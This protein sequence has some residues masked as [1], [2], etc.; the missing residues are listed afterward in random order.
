MCLLFARGSAPLTSGAASIF[1][2]GAA[3]RVL[4]RAPVVV[5]VLREDPSHSPRE[6]APPH[7]R[8]WEHL[9]ARETKQHSRKHSRILNEGETV[10]GLKE[11]AGAGARTS[12]RKGVAGKRAP[13]EAECVEECLRRQRDAEK[14]RRPPPNRLGKDRVERRRYQD[15]LVGATVTQRERLIFTSRA[16]RC[17]QQPAQ[18]VGV[19]REQSLHPMQ[20]RGG[21]S[22]LLRTRGLL[23]WFGILEV[24]LPVLILLCMYIPSLHWRAPREKQGGSCGSERPE[25]DHGRQVDSIGGR[26]LHA[27]GPQASPEGRMPCRPRSPTWTRGT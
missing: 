12:K 17:V 16:S 1:M 20:G 9:R 11:T 19:P 15:R 27:F 21:Q 10:S 5:A 23:M 18:H 24:L 4:A 8:Q 26:L 7:C 25:G 14:S 3:A 6:S 2:E 22:G 13:E